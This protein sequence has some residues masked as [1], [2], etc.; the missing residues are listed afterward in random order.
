LGV[1][2]AKCS[3]PKG[4]E[5]LET[6]LET[7][8]AARARVAATRERFDQMSTEKLGPLHTLDA[9]CADLGIG[10]TSLYGRIK[11]GDLVAVKLGQKTRVTDESL[12]A[13]KRSL[14]AA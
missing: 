13:F 4:G 9:V 2:G 8:Q 14:R 3:R 5:T 6:S 11:N 1:G 12:Q 7:A 10:K